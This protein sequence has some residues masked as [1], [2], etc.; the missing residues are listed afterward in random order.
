MTT[1]A[2]PS[3]T[4]SATGSTW[5]AGTRAR[6]IAV[7]FWPALTVISVTSCLT[8]RSNAWVPGAASGPRTDMFSESASALN[9]TDRAT[10]F[11]W[12]RSRFAVLAEPVKLSRSC[13]VEV[14]E[15][16]AGAAADQLER[17]LGEDLR[18]DDQLHHLR[19]EVAGLRGRLDEARH[20]GDERGGQLFQRAPDGEVEGVDLHGDPEPRGEQVLA[21]ERALLAERLGRPFDEHLLVGQLALGLARVAEQDADAAVDVE[22][23]VAEGRAGPVGELV[24][25]VAV[26]AQQLADRLRQLGALVEG[27]LAQGRAAD[28]PAVGEGGAEVDARGGD[29][30]DRLAG[31]RVVDRGAAVRREPAACDV[32]ADYC[33]ERS[34]VLT[35]AISLYIPIIR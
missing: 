12:L 33:H 11:G 19:G 16:V 35:I 14:V 3:L 9:L 24:Q 17:A 10:T 15:Q 27:Q 13:S 25:L 4:A 28:L 7:H 29:L 2:S 6:R 26:L 22:L 32:A 23:R 18:V 5:S 20:A 1:L 34:S 31:D 8:Y 30:G 21:E